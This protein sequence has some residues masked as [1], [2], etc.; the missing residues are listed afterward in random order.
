MKYIISDESG[1]I[2]IKF[3]DYK[4]DN[5]GILKTIK[6]DVALS[7]IIVGGNNSGERHF[8]ELLEELDNYVKN[9]E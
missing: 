6:Y 7:M 8:N 3:E 2:R 5:N 1:E 9:N 4:S